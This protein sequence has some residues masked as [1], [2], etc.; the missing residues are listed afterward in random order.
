MPTIEQGQTTDATPLT[1][2]SVTLGAEAGMIQKYIH[3]SAYTSKDVCAAGEAL[4]VWSKNASAAPV[5]KLSSS[6]TLMTG[7]L[8]PIALSATVS[9]NDCLVQVT[10]LAATTIN[11]SVSIETDG[12]TV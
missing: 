2:H 5:V 11:W 4:L 9:G 6:T 7:Y 10:G 3:W 12:Q 1:L 8:S